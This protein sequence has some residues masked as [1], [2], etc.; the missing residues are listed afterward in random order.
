MSALSALRTPGTLMLVFMVFAS[1]T[2]ADEKND[3]NGRPYYISAPEK[4][5]DPVLFVWCHPSGGNAKPDFDWWKS[6]RISKQ[7]VILLCPQSKKRLWSMKHDEP[8]VKKTHC[9]GDK[10]I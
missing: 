7:N 1:P 5:A 2:H 3:L 8:F 6:G 4:K 10:G 9:E